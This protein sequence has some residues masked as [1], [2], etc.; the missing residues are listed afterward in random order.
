MKSKLRGQGLDLGVVL[1]GA[2]GVAIVPA[3]RMLKSK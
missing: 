3:S 2:D 1:P